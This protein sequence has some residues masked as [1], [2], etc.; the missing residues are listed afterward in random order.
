MIKILRNSYGMVKTI[1]IWEQLISFEYRERA[2][3]FWYFIP[4]ELQERD[5]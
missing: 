4:Q 5:L 3:S 2:Q 1:C